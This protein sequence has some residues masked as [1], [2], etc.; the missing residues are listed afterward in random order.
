MLVRRAFQ[1]CVAASFTA[2]TNLFVSDYSGNISTLE[3]TEHGGH[4]SLTKT[5][6]NAGCAP[7]PSWLTLDTN[8]NTL[9]CLDEGLEVTNGSL[10]SFTINSSGHLHK[11]HRERTISGPVSGVIY[12]NPAEKR[13]IAL[14]HYSGS[15]LSTWNLDANHTAAFDF[16]Q[17]IFFNLTKPGPNAERQDAPHEHEAVLDPT[18]NFI[19]VPDLGADLIRIFS[20]DAGSGDLV[21][22]EPF[23]VLPGSGPRH[24]VFYQPYGVVGTQATTFMFLVSE[25]ANT[26]TSFRVSYPK[27][28]GMGFKQV[29]ETSTYGDLVVPEGNA[30]A[31]IAV[32]PDNRFLI[33]SNRNNTSFHIPSPSS[34]PHNHTTSIPSDSLSTFSLQK[35]GTLK[36][37]QLWPSGGMFPRHFSLNKF[38]D[39]LAVG[40]QYDRS[41]VVFERDV[42]LGTVGKPVA[43]WVGGGN[44]TCVVWEE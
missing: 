40:M 43:R 36:H 7:N 3:L 37:I 8:H 44:V 31:E 18:G 26:V 12:G 6:A 5:S 24:V 42:A 27:A 14:A 25:L 21:A 30:A 39:L 22:E 35:D 38:G 11:I 33:I 15:A 16:Q 9:Y 23:A 29:F 1:L 13:S 34:I 17:D 19:V 32:T 20:I 28:G 41:V 10:T 4:Y 2:A